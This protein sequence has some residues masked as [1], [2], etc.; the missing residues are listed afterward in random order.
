MEHNEA[1]NRLDEYFDGELQPDVAAEVSLHVRS[2]PACKAALEERSGLAR[3]LS[4]LARTGP[5]EAF[6]QRVME[7]LEGA[8]VAQSAGARWLTPALAASLA[9]AMLFIALGLMGRTGENGS[10]EQDPLKAYVADSAED[11]Q[12]VAGNAETPTP[13]QVLGL[14]VEDVS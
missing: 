8:P 3:A 12:M 2:C 6:V 1:W 7:R 5:S 10:T 13:D 11:I 14:L 4:G 9:V